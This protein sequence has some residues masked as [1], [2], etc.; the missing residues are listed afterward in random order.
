MVAV[1]FNPAYAGLFCN[2]NKDFM[3]YY[4]CDVKEMKID[5]SITMYEYLRLHS[6][7]RMT[8]T[9]TITL[10]QI[11]DIFDI[12]LSGTGSYMRKDGRFD[13]HNFESKVLDPVCADLAKCKMVQLI[14]Q[15]DKNGE[16][17]PYRR[18]KNGRKLIGYEFTWEVTDRPGV[19]DAN[20]AMETQRAIE[21]NPQILK[22]A[23]DIHKGKKKNKSGRSNAFNNFEQNQYNFDELEK[24]ILDN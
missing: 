20:E 8:N 7:T 12:P 2:I 15:E 19:S 9:R 5:R 6:D 11:R 16:L 4:K 1:D 3:M 14:S 13:R 22:I 17:Q 23:H 18:V 21:K 10:D 24:E